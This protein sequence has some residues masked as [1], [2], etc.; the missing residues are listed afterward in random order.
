MHFLFFSFVELKIENM[1]RQFVQ[2][3]SLLFPFLSGLSHLLGNKE[4]YL[5]YVLTIERVM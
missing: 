4:K 5:F 2:F 3:I 1:S